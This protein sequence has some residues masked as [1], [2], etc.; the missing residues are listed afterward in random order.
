MGIG[1]CGIVESVILLG[2]CVGRED[3]SS[4]RSIHSGIAVRSLCYVFH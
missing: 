1:E 2:D 4:L 3:S